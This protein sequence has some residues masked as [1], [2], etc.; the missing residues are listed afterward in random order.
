MIHLK[1][2]LII[3]M[4]LVSFSLLVAES[5]LVS[6][7]SSGAYV[8]PE[9]AKEYYFSHS[10][11]TDDFHL[12][13]SGKWAVRF[14]FRTAYPSVANCS[15]NVQKARLFLPVTGDSVRV[16]LYSEVASL[17]SQLITTAKVAVSA[18]LLDINFPTS[19]Q[20]ETIWLVVD[21]ATN[22][23]NRFVSASAG[24]G[25]RSYYLNTNA[26]NPY[27][28][29]LS[30][31][32]FNCELLFGLIGSF[33]LDTPDLQLVSFDLSGQLLPRQTVKPVFSIYN[34]SNN[35]IADAQI[36]LQISSPTPDYSFEHNIQVSELIMPNSQFEVAASGYHDFNIDL[37]STAMQI[38]VQA[39]LSSSMAETDTTL[40]NNA[41]NKYYSVFA[42]G[43]PVIPV[44]TFLRFSSTSSIC[45][46]QDSYPQN[47]VHNLLYYPN[48]SDSLSNLASYQRH[49]WYGSNANPMTAVMG[50]NKIIGF[51]STDYL[52]RYQTAVSAAQLKRSFIS[53]A[54][55]L[56]QESENGE[57]LSVQIQLSNAN[58]NLYTTSTLN[59]VTNSRFFVGLFKLHNFSGSSRFV[60]DKWIAFADTINNTMN[61]GA[62]IT[63]SYNIS[64]VNL[65]L[66]QLQAGYRI[67]YW[68]QDKSGGV[69]YYANF[70]NFNLTSS[71]IS[72]DVSE[73]PLRISAYPN[74]LRGAG[75]MHV[76]LNEA[77]VL[78]V[79]NIKG[80]CVWES[81][82][83]CKDAELPLS[84]FP[85][86]GIYF[87]RAEQ[88]NLSYLTQ[89]I[90]VIK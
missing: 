2:S 9:E 56:L 66:E 81:H 74:P 33:N 39:T 63:K 49:S 23:A 21:Y 28:Q 46:I 1:R 50:D 41:I 14:D 32:G 82:T 31:A 47:G 90:S 25:E 76:K 83:S 30:Q 42:Y 52:S 35:I 69:I 10:T 11:G 29:S 84:M 57:N 71:A 68:L 38:R 60:L 26:V 58:T 8:F 4:L 7:P 51:N 44:E 22:L 37:P 67:Y 73:L 40:M 72:E 3:L 6:I 13:G 70:N 87:L 62:S 86:S 53:S 55:C 20:A 80:Q 45:T 59:P 34:H 17:P 18:N 78:K 19:V 43:N 16:S 77:R 85:S 61:S 54:I 79:F 48:L 36:F 5:A 89:R 88:A 75:T 15:F 27:F 12:Y 65:S 64:L 24:G